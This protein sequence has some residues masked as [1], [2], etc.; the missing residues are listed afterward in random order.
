MS[1]EGLEGGDD[2]ASEGSAIRQLYRR[3]AKRYDAV[4][5][6]YPLFGVRMARFRSRAAEALRLKPGDT[7]V[8]LG[9]GTGLNFGILQDRIGPNGSLIGVDLTDAMLS[10]ARQRVA[11][12]GWG[13]VE[14]VEADLAEYAVPQGADA[15]LSTFAMTLVPEYDAVIKGVP[16]LLLRSCVHQFRRVSR[17][18]ERRRVACGRPGRGF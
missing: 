1:P 9:C 11:E 14:L 3:R 15:V 17:T 5:W 4:T 12:A 10:R 2:M 8:E 7:V 16:G 6:I 18:L 13:N